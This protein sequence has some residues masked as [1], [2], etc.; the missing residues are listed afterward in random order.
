[1]EF[2][3]THWLLAWNCISFAKKKKKIKI[4]PHTDRHTHT[5]LIRLNGPE[6]N[7]G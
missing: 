4:I 1:M 5:V 6:Q 7:L 2:I 3:V